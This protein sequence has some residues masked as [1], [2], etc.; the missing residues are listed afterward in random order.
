MGRSTGRAPLRRR[1]AVWVL[2]VVGL[3]AIYFGVSAIVGNPV[4]E[5]SQVIAHRGG[6]AYQPENTMAAFAQAVE[7][8][9]DWLE[10]D[11]QM[12]NDGVLVVI[13]DET[14]DRTTNG[15]GAVADLTL[16][17]LKALDAGDGQHIPT[18]AEVI[19]LAA[20]AGVRIL[21]EA[22]SPR[23]YPGIEA[24]MI[25]VIAAA[26]Y[27]DRT[28]VQSF[29]A[30]ALETLHRLD[31]DLQ[32]CALYGQGV[33]TLDEQQPG[34]AQYVC[35][36][37]EMVVINPAMVRVAHRSGRQVFAWFGRLENPATM[38]ALLELGV[39]GLIVDDHRALLE[40]IGR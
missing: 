32:L 5:A 7:D 24:A 15:T 25:E 14:V 4:V 12:S 39:D 23:L 3:V 21:P 27:T 22:K 38:R 19:D 17:E 37:A 18:F 9:A 34:D 20:E 1:L 10:F 31:P 35:P 33:M 6:R 28:V 16:S 2:I 8:G 36:M 30:R 11:V 29:D 13:H 40:V 26:G